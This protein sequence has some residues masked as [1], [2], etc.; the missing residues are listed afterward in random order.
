MLGVFP[1][2]YHSRRLRWQ[3]VGDVFVAAGS[4]GDK[5][6][7][8]KALLHVAHNNFLQ[9]FL[10]DGTETTGEDIAGNPFV[11]LGGIGLGGCLHIIDG[12]QL[13]VFYLYQF[14]RFLGALPG[15]GCYQGYRIPHET[16]GAIQDRPVRGHSTYPPGDI[17][18]GE[19]C[20]NPRVCLCLTGVDVLYTGM[21]I[22]TTQ[23]PPL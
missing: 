2:G 21:G 7:L 16:H 11:N 6:G 5:V 1:G 22:R 9:G 20:L 15:L 8:F 19:Y 10:S 18:V 3:G 13:F 23:N 12:R 14:Q 4:L 17:L